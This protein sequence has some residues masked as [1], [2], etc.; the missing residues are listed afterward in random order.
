MYLIITLREVDYEDDQKTDG[1]IVCKEILR[2]GKLHIE[3]RLKDTT[4]WEKS[5][6]EAKVRIGL[7]CH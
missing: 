1:R 6:N 2:N 5:I 3:K 4:D 7:K